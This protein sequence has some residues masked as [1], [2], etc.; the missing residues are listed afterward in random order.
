MNI[1]F[2]YRIA[3]FFYIKKIPFI[4]NLIFF[5][6]YLLFN[7]VVPFEAKIGKGTKFAYGGIAVVIHKRAVIGEKCIIGVGVTVGGTS[8]IYEVPIIGNCVQV[9]AGAKILGPVKIGDNVII[10]ANAVV[11]SNIPANSV[12][13]GVPAKVIKSNIN[14]NDYRDDV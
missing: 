6:Q 4:P 11:L 14:I 10:G 12:A 7:S 8:K 9:S 1:F 3:H 13:V 2:L 5:F